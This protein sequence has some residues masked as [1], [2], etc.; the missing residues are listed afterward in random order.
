M[1]EIDMPEL[2]SHVL[3]RV[4]TRT[5]AIACRVAPGSRLMRF[6]SGGLSRKRI[7][8]GNRPVIALPQT[9]GAT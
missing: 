3:L 9:D 6:L 4:T 8:R 7:A 2:L 5:D 1:T